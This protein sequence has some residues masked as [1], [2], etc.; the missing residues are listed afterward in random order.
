MPTTN[1]QTTTP[2]SNLANQIN[3]DNTTTP[4]S[5]E[6]LD[7]DINLDEATK[8]NVAEL[9][10]NKE[11]E[12]KPTN[13]TVN[14][15]TAS[16]EDLSL[17][18]PDSYFTEK[19]EEPV[20]K[21]E[22]KP[23]IIQTEITAEKTTEKTDTT[24]RLQMQDQKNREEEK[25]LFD[26]KI[27]PEIPV[28]V[29][30]NAPISSSEIVSEIEPQAVAQIENLKENIAK[31]EPVLNVDINQVKPWSFDIEKTNYASD[32][33]IIED[34]GG[35]KPIEQ[36]NDI[37]MIIGE[38]KENNVVVE[39]NTNNIDLDS[40]IESNQTTN[41]IVSIE[42]NKSEVAKVEDNALFPNFDKIEEKKDGTTELT[43]PIEVKTTLDI[44][45]PVSGVHTNGIWESGKWGHLRKFLVPAGV[46]S[47]LAVLWYFIF[48]TMYPVETG[49]IIDDT[50]QVVENTWTQQTGTV[51][52][53]SGGIAIV[54][55]GSM[56][57]EIAVAEETTNTEESVHWASPEFDSLW[58]LT[59]DMTSQGQMEE[60]STVTK[61]KAISEDANAFLA[62]WQAT[63]N[64]I[65]IKYGTAITKKCTDLIWALENSQEI[66]NL[67]GNLAQL[68]GYLQKL[69]DIKNAGNQ[70]QTSGTIQEANSE[71]WQTAPV[72]ETAVAE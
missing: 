69:R 2:A 26:A 21:E 63:N 56:S 41:D 46:I 45:A 27:E 30:I 6:S 32:M 67:E 61:L 44:N 71:S 1:D 23:E 29:D 52:D 62:E 15:N 65:Y 37:G 53:L 5:E 34:M 22:P 40:L 43:S 9:D 57:G 60:Q 50:P 17:D 35:S 54:D 68:E 28:Q 49:K 24:D 13:M 55:T 47:V 70:Q 58:E 12:V 64:K 38:K 48:T 8:D 33:K 66:D 72:Q 31:I 25:S 18:L 16:E 20:L 51:E 59:D 39:K 7:F 42:P 19:V 11:T 4:K 14:N 10:I 3:T 36:N